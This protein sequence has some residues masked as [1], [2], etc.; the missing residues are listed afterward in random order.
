MAVEHFI[1]QLITSFQIGHVI[2]LFVVVSAERH[3]IVL[4]ISLFDINISHK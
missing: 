1:W 2:T 3:F 4:Y